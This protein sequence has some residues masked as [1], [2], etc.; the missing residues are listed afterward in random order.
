MI[1]HSGINNTKQNAT[2]FKL[3]ANNND[4]DNK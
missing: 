1:M 4:N 3:F 2:I